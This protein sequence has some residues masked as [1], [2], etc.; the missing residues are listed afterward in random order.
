MNEIWKNGQVGKVFQVERGYL[1]EDETPKEDQC[2]DI[3]EAKKGKKSKQLG[4]PTRQQHIVFKASENTEDPLMIDLRE[5]RPEYNGY[6]GKSYWS[7]IYF[8]LTNYQSI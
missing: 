3:Q 1:R 2:R 6:N 8:H 4:T 5:N 7:A